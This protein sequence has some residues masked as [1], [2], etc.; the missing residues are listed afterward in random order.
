VGRLQVMSELPLA[1]T[2]PSLVAALAILVFLGAIGV[3]IGLWASRKMGY[4]PQGG[5]GL[6]HFRTAMRRGREQRRKLLTRGERVFAWTMT[7]VSAVAAPAGVI[8]LLSGG[9]SPRPVGITLL[10]LALVV[11]AIPISPILRAR[12]RRRQRANGPGPSRQPRNG[13][14]PVDRQ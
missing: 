5:S 7:V 6:G 12:A 11:T 8:I 4:I 3:C 1:A 9:P 10:V 13:G 2:V 14:A